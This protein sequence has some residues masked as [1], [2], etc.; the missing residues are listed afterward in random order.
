MLISTH[1]HIMKSNLLTQFSCAPPNPAPVNSPVPASVPPKEGEYD[2][3]GFEVHVPT[4]VLTRTVQERRTLAR[5]DGRRRG[6]RG[7][8]DMH[9]GGAS[10]VLSVS[11]GGC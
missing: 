10:A 1:K 5:K 9:L 11:W 8:V 7:L 4:V 2:C 3:T 6:P